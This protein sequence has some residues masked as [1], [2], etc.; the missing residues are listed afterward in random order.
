MSDLNGRVVTL[1][2]RRNGRYDH[3][4]RFRNR[5]GG[6]PTGCVFEHEL[7]IEEKTEV[8]VSVIGD[9]VTITSPITGRIFVKKGHRTYMYHKHRS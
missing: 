3:D 9:S 2:K 1:T 7:R 6:E 4:V 5:R 8:S